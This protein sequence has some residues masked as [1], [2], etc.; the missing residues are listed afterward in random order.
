MPE[1][2]MSSG[3]PPVEALAA[4][5]AS[6]APATAP[7]DRVAELRRQ[8]AYHSARYHQDDAPE[9]ADFE[10][11]ALVLE[12]TELEASHPELASAVSPTATVGAPPSP[13]FAPVQHALRM[14]SLDNVFSVD[15]L[16]AWGVRLERLLA[17]EPEAR[18]AV[19]FVCEPKIDG[20]AMSLRYERGT[21]VRAATRGDGTTGED[22]T[23]NVRTIGVIPH[24]LTLPAT[25]LPEVLEVRGEVYLP[26]AA[27]EELNR[28]QLEAGLRPFANPR[29]SAAGS[30]RQ[31]DPAVTAERPLAFFA[32]GLGEV[33]GGPL[34][35]RG[36]PLERQ[37]AALELLARAGFPV[38]PMIRR[39]A[40]LDGVARYCAEALERRHDLDYEIDG[41]VVK[42][43]DVALQRRLGAT[44]HAPRWAV[45]Y[46]FPPEER[47]TL[48]KQILVSIG[49]TGRA[50]PFAALE[51]VV[52]AGSTVGLASLHN[53]DQVAL[54]DL[55][56]GDTVIVRKAGD[57]IPEV[58][59]PVLAARPPDAAPWRFPTTCPGCG[60]P[61]VRLEG[62]SDTFCIN[63]DCPAQQLQRIAHFAARSAMDIEG[64]GEMRVGQ[65]IGAGLVHDVAD[66]YRLDLEALAA[67]EG[68][69][70]VSARNLLAAIDASR[71]RGM[72]RLLVALSIHH[73]GP[74]IAAA[75]AAA[76]VDLDALGAASE[77]QLS[78]IDQVGGT[79][80]ASVVA[81]F[82]SE[83]NRQVIEKLRSAGVAFGSD[84]YRSPTSEEAA[85][86]PLAGRSVVVT[87]TLEGFSREEAEAAIL[88]RGGKSPGS[89]SAKTFAVVVGAEPGAAKLSKA[90][91]LGIPILDEA[92]FRRLLATGELA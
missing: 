42:V 43:D 46:K 90:E 57:V 31:K 52:V 74:T 2:T 9:I 13:A 84:R 26:L 73:V 83:R 30:L 56:E 23:A 32:Y 48:L 66:L 11:D 35:G 4:R 28:R 25:D 64:L 5:A 47:T 22:V 40:E 45:A 81:F 55:R 71:A 62:E 89:V 54:K 20:L 80:A 58:V 79:I 72:T 53:E 15:E 19:A 10:Y 3:R 59:G 29:N 34:A 18:S 77:E 7:A 36:G 1:P 37:S 70:E 82:A 49:R 21:L 91:Q 88:E 27:F 65:L 75:L 14:L 24:E 92:A 16:T 67:L 76:I 68:F 78:A 60:G 17:G 44:S 38:N 50:T 39:E 63:V 8:I 41:V 85:P 33:R 61:L 6:E 69:G 86:L 51:P 12:L 87:G